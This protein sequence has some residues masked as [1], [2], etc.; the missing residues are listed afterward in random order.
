MTTHNWTHHLFDHAQRAPKQLY[1]HQQDKARGTISKQATTQH[2][3]TNETWSVILNHHGI[4]GTRKNEG[5]ERR[6]ATYLQNASANNNK[7]QI[8]IWCVIK[9]RSNANNA[10]RNKS[11]KDYKGTVKGNNPK[12]NQRENHK[13]KTTTAKSEVINRT[14]TTARV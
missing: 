5:R 13:S 1:D 11:M 10:N 7:W 14:V 2:N 4:V 12:T 9:N 6:D 3:M 8:W